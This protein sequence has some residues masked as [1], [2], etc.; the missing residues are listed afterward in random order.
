MATINRRR[1]AIQ[2]DILCL[3]GMIAELGEKLFLEQMVLLE[4]DEGAAAKVASAIL[5]RDL[6]KHHLLGRLAELT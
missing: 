3:F 4:H 2:H 5:V 1:A 6:E